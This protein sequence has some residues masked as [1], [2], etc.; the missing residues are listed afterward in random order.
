MNSRPIPF[1]ILPL[2]EQ[3]LKELEEVG[4]LEKVPS[5]RWA[6]P[7]I[8]ILEKNNR[9]IICG[10]FNISVNPNLIVDDH[11]LPTVN[12]LLLLWWMDKFL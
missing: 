8:P 6:T 11:S 5:S 3:E 9:V 10:D 7:I 2:I 1:K 4:D 12:E